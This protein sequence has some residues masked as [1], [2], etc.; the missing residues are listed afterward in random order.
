M[1]EFGLLVLG[2]EIL[3]FYLVVDLSLLFVLDLQD[4][5]SFLVLLAMGRELHVFLS[6]FFNEFVELVGLEKSLMVLVIE[7]LDLL[8]IVL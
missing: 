1:L 7:L 4:L 2:H 6:E 5:D 3:G 8:L